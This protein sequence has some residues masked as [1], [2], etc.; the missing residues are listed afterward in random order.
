MGLTDQ[1]LANYYNPGA[2]ALFFN[3]DAGAVH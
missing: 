1:A 2:L 3:P